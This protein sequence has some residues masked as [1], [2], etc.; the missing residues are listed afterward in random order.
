MCKHGAGIDDA[1]GCSL[2]LVIVHEP[3]H[4]FRHGKIALY[5]LWKTSGV[6]NLSEGS[7]SLG[8]NAVMLIS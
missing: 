6:F 7:N 1:D 3:Q 2:V 4:Y 8:F 5:C